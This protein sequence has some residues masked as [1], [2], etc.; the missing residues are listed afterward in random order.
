MT[1]VSGDPGHLGA[2][3][4]AVDDD[5]AIRALIRAVLEPAGYS[6]IEASDGEAGLRAIEHEPVD[7][8]LLDMRMPGMDGYQFL[9]RLLGMANIPVVAVTGSGDCEGLLLEARGGV[10][11][12]LAKPFT[13][14]Q[15]EAAVE[16]ALARSG[17]E[18]ASKREMMSRSAGVY[19]SMLRLS[20]EARKE[21]QRVAAEPK[22]RPAGIRGLI[23]R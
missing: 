22:P 2:K 1:D 19:E 16:A 13:P 8:I 5:P 6:I 12:H 23:R 18:L 15:L 20:E 21:A 14:D 11:D 4:L 9:G 17:D 3:I 10:V 7:L